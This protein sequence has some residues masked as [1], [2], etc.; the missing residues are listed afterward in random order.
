MKIE[1]ELVKL[2]NLYCWKPL[3]GLVK[4]QQAGRGFAGAVVIS[5]GA[6]IAFSAELCVC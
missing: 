5:G 3:P 2:K 6:A 4:T 1:P